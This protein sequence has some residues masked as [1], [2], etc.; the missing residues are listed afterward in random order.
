MSLADFWEATPRET[1]MF[2]RAAAWR[3]EERVRLTIMHAW[4]TAAL[5]GAN[6]SKGGMPKL[7]SIL[8]DRHQRAMQPL[9]PEQEVGHWLRWADAQDPSGRET[10]P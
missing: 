4:H 5:A 6:F 7:S 2:I 8:P 10:K 9:T 1:L 3:S